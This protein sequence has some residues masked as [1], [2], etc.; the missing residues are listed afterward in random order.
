MSELYRSVFTQAM[1]LP[2]AER[3]TL[4]RELVESVDADATPEPPLTFADDCEEFRYNLM[5]SRLK[6]MEEN[7][8]DFT[9]GETFSRELRERFGMPAK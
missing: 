4:S 8:D 1:T 6:D 7:P 3:L 2:S 9:D 5:M